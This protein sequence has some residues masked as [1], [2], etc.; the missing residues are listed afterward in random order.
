MDSV[1]KVLIQRLMT[2]GRVTHSQLG[3]TLGLSRQ[4]VAERIQRL[5]QAGVIRGYAAVVDPA[6]LGA[7]LTA[8]IGVVIERPED[9]E[10]F[11]AEVNRLHQVQECHHVAGEDNYLLKVRTPGTRGLEHLLTQVLKRIPGVVR[12]RTTVVL[13]SPKE[14]VLPP[15]PGRAGRP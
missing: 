8:F 4:T 12:T 10:N 15:M 9:C 2:D 11:L 3:E 7:D 1:D 13:S 5:E 6:A 14:T